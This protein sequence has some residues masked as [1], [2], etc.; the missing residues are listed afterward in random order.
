MKRISL[1]I[2]IETLRKIDKLVK[3]GY[4]RSRAEVIREAIRFL[5]KRE[6]GGKYGK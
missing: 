5:L 2:E 1:R 4:Y 3:E 6:I